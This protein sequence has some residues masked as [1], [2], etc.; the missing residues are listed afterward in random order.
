MLPRKYRTTQ[1]PG[2]DAEHPFPDNDPEPGPD[3]CPTCHRP[4]FDPRMSGL[5]DMLTLAQAVLSDMKRCVEEE[6][7]P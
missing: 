3:R 7:L 5:L 1:V 6:S 4:W 2:P